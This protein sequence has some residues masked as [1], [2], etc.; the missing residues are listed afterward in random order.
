MN[1][2]VTAGGDLRNDGQRAPAHEFFHGPAGH[3]TGQLSPRA[4]MT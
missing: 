4:I 1:C 2:I 3:G